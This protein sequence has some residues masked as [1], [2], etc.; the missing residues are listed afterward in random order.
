MKKKI[1]FILAVSLLL[2]C[3]MGGNSQEI[4]AAKKATSEGLFRLKT[5][6]KVLYVG[7]KRRLKLAKASGLKVKKITYKSLNKKVA[8]VTKK[9]L[10]KG[11][12]AGKA[13]IRLTISYVKKGV[14]G[15]K[16]LYYTCKVKKPASKTKA[17][18][19][20]TASPKVATASPK[21]VTASPKAATP[22]PTPALS[23]EQET[24][25]CM[26]RD[27]VAYCL[28]GQAFSF[29]V[30]NLPEGAGEYSFEVED[31]SVLQ[32]DQKGQALALTGGQTQ[33]TC[34]DKEG[35]LK[36]VY[37]V[38]VVDPDQ[39]DFVNVG[40]RGHRL[41]APENTLS[42]IEL[43]LDSFDGVEIDIYLTKDQEYAVLHNETLSEYT[44]SDK[45]VGELTLEEVQ[46]LKITKGIEAALEAYPNEHIPSL[47]Q[48]LQLFGQEKYKDKRL[49]IEIKDKGIS[50]EL[51]E[52]LLKEAK[53]TVGDLSQIYFISFDLANLQEIRKLTDV[54]GDKVNMEYLVWEATDEVLES[55]VELR[56]QIGC[57]HT[58]ITKEDVEFLHQQGLTANVWI[59]PDLVKMY[60]YVAEWGVDVVSSDEDLVP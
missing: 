4:R 60:Q 24:I 30:K 16:K 26:D 59:V 47:T 41:K 44:D 57:K 36:L 49:V 55:C 3:F 14:K 56:A 40:H 18:R 31:S 46:T 2:T 20:A 52:K 35:N 42:S 15:K 51:L 27:G 37:P 17:S 10:V 1:S 48:V 19:K 28:K 23:I 32:L 50:P 12:K 25:Y 9:G 38:K 33:V 13:K 11:K 53:E 5:S 22:S 7:K 43:G 8:T 54:G 39:M 45:V 29:K 58:G 6:K 34:T 21:V